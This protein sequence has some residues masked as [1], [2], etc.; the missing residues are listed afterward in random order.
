MRLS[1]M[2]AALVGAVV[3]F[4]GPCRAQTPDT[5]DVSSQ[6]ELVI[7]TKEAPPFAMKAADGD[8]ARHQYRSLAPR[9]RRL[10][11]HYRFVEEPDVQGLID[12][13]AAG[14]F[15]VAVAP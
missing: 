8:L 15:D 5:A 14:K 6:R 4:A 2:F 9:R 10:H 7:G 13:V 1:S 11:L 3:T 12:G